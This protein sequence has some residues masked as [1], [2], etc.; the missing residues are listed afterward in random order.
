[1]ELRLRRDII[2]LLLRWD[3]PLL[4]KERPQQTA[5]WEAE[6]RPAGGRAFAGIKIARLASSV[7][8]L[9]KA[10]VAIPAGKRGATAPGWRQR[11]TGDEDY[12]QRSCQ[13]HG[14]SSQAT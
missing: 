9:R 12:R 14:A 5:P 1:M 11:Q 3:G 2:G 6:V 4:P 10:G 13:Q 7:T 8:R